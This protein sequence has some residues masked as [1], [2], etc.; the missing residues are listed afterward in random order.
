MLKPTLWL[1]CGYK[2]T[3][4]NYC[5]YHLVILN[6]FK[7][8]NCTFLQ[9]SG[10]IT[11]SKN[12]W[13]HLPQFPGLWHRLPC[14]DS[15]QLGIRSH[16]IRIQDKFSRQT[17]RGWNLVDYIPKRGDFIRLTFD[18]QAGHEQMGSR[19]A[20]V[21]SLTSFNRKISI[22]ISASLWISA[23]LYPHPPAGPVLHRFPEFLCTCYGL[24]PCTGGILSPAR[25]QSPPGWITAADKTRF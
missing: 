14:W 20:L 24:F 2:D 16:P 17:W 12:L 7:S 18:P 9:T 1:N 10:K 3:T 5:I 11:D 13:Y 6:I 23:N 8:Q 21:L 22:F 19:L 25:L 15:A 4:G